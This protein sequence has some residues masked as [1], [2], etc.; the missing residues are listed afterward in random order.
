MQEK[1]NASELMTAATDSA[2]KQLE[3]VKYQDSDAITEQFNAKIDK[4]SEHASAKYTQ[5]K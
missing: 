1:K 2:A 5:K 4:A 3:G